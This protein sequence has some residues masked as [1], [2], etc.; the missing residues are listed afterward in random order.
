MIGGYAL[1]ENRIMPFLPVAAVCLLLAADPVAPPADEAND[2]SFEENLIRGVGF[3]PD[4]PGLMAY[5][6]SLSPTEAEM[7]RLADLVPQLGDE[8]FSAREGASKTL[9]AAGRPALALLKAAARSADAET[10]R[11]AR[12]CVEEIESEPSAAILTAAARLLAV[13]K[14]DGATAALLAA[15]PMVQDDEAEEAVLAALAAVG[16]REGKAAAELTAAAT[17]TTAARRCAAAFVLG[18]GDGEDK[19]LAVRLLDDGEPL[20]R[21]RAALGL[22]RG[23]DARGAAPLAALIGDGPE[24][25]AWRAEEVLIR[26]AGEAA[27]TEGSSLTDAAGRRVARAAW[28]T[29]WKAEGAK[30]DLGRVNRDE[31]YLGL[32]LIAELDEHP[33]GGGGSG[34]VWECGRDGKMRWELAGLQRPIDVRPLPRGRILVAEYGANRVT[35]R[36]RKGNVLWERRT[37]NSPTSCQRLP[38]GNTLISTWDQIEEVTRDQKVVFTKKLT[39]EMVTNAQKLRGGNYL[40]ITMNGNA[41]EIDATQREVAKYAGTESHGWGSVE[42]VGG[43]RVL[44]SQMQTNKVVEADARGAILRTLNLKDQPAHATRL[45]NG[46]ILVSFREAWYVAEFTPEGKEVWR[47]KTNGRPFHAWG[48]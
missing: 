11:R 31:D 14:P 17:S 6:R 9:R 38:N 18:Q 3:R 36:D 35:E 47:V 28:E 34:R 44:V 2:L 12:V 13:Q 39:N 24:A 33:R 5:L 16:L 37:A 48:R 27:P 15:L 30:V 22:L 8:R 1:V 23:G 7:A 10:A 41:V 42:R 43:G 19:R 40:Y 26:L 29:W 25:L 46:N 4:G 20:V 45:R 21:Y 32:T